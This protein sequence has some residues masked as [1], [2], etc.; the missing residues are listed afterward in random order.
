[1][2]LS[3][4]ELRDLTRRKRP[5]AQMRVLAQAGIPF[6]VVAGR[7]VVVKDALYEEVSRRSRFTAPHVLERG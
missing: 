6:N 3:D 2:W 7:P 1:M 5:S 4:A